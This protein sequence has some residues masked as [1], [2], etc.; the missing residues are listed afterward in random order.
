LD[1]LTLKKGAFSMIS[2]STTGSISSPEDPDLALA[3]QLSKETG[4]VSLDVLPAPKDHGIASNSNSLK[5]LPGVVYE[6][7]AIRFVME[8]T[9]DVHL[10]LVAEHWTKHSAMIEVLLCFAQ[11]GYDQRWLLVQRDLIAALLDA[12]MGEASPLSGRLYSVQ[13]RKRAPS[14]L[15]SVP[16]LNSKSNPAGKFCFICC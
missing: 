6:S 1:L 16:A 7:F 13:S 8:L 12:I 9:M 2:S 14:S 5:P 11:L 10:Q 4:P 3:L 15:V